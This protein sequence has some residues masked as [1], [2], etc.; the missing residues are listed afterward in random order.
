L[1]ESA[2]AAIA[3]FYAYTPPKVLEHCNSAASVIRAGLQVDADFCMQMN[4]SQSVAM[5]VGREEET[6][7]LILEKCY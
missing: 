1:H 7:L 4:Q 3:M 5:V 2:H 6:G